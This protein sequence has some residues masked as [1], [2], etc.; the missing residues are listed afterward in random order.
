MF[1]ILES[2][3]TSELFLAFD[4]EGQEEQAKDILGQM[5]ELGYDSHNAILNLG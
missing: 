2:E 5:A 3:Y 1:D 4:F